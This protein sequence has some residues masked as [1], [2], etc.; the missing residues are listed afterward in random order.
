MDCGVNCVFVVLVKVFVG[1][2][3]LLLFVLRCYL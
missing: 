3:V 2:C 1:F